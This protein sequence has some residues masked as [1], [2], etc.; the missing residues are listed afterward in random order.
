MGNDQI[1]QAYNEFNKLQGEIDELNK[2]LSA[3]RKEQSVHEAMLLK[4]IK[5]NE[6]KSGIRHVVYE[7]KTPRYKEILQQ[8]RER[9][10][11]KTKQAELDVI[12]DEMT[13]V[14]KTHKFEPEA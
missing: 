4:G 1:R 9:F 7:R 8:A 5:E 12:I 14:T 13:T 2:Q 3:K 10:I 11:A 6:A